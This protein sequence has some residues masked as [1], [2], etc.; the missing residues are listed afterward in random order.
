[1]AT[2][3]K[4]IAE[5]LK[6]ST[7]AVSKALN[8]KDDVSEELKEKV[9]AV[10]KEL[11]YSPNYFA[12]KLV[13][14]KSNT[15]GV[16]IL[17]KEELG[18]DEYFGFRFVEGIMEEANAND[19]DILL[20]S[21]STEK[22]YQALAREKH[23]EG[24]IFIALRLDDPYLEDFKNFGIP[25]S[26]IDLY[27]RGKNISFI[28]SDSEVGIKKGLDYL[29]ELGHRDIVIVSAYEESQIAQNRFEAYK[30]Y[31]EE[32]GIFREKNVYKGDFTKGSGYRAG[33]EILKRDKLPSAVFAVSDLMAIGVLHAFEDNGIKVPE[34]ISILGFDNISASGYMKP[35]LTTIGQ[36][37]K[38]I[39][40]EAVSAILKR[41]N[42]SVV[43][44]KL[45]IEPELI[46]R[47]TC[48]KR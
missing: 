22:S 16:F 46:I 48:K 12:R 23:V 13:T 37:A 28:S 1:M 7:A 2:T 43:K 17:G 8:N 38:A 10:A 41:I 11:E 27:L 33:L 29:W 20:F 25:V 19:Y 40:K 32:K 21:T 44:K 3:I 26:I 47:E 9:R 15:I 14:N 39:G 45:L 30:N 35:S 34:D 31:L 4:D 42:G 18:I 5:A 36:D 6:I 24:V